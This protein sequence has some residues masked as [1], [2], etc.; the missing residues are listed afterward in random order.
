MLPPYSSAHTHINI[1]FNLI[2]LSV[3]N[4]IT[5]DIPIRL[6]HVFQD[7]SP[8]GRVGPTA[9]VERAVFVARQL[10]CA[11]P[12]GSAVSLL[13]GSFFTTTTDLLSPLTLTNL[14]INITMFT[15]TYH[16]HVALPTGWPHGHVSFSILP[17]SSSEELS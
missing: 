7:I 16:G 4:A 3:W 9:L 1:T 15:I 11:G 6:G 2:P 13:L 8:T 10:V 5:T 14:Y 17:S 12:T